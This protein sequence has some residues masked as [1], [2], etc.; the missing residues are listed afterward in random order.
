M[1]SYEKNKSSGLWSVRFREVNSDG[2][3]H[4]KR[5]SGY[6]TKKEA[7]YGY[8]D[9]IKQKETSDKIAEEKKKEKEDPRNIKFDSLL[10]MYFSF[11]EQRV[12]ETTLY[13]L[14]NKI[15]NKILPFFTG[16]K[17]KEITPAKI[18]EWQQT[19][20]EYSYKYQKNLNA[21]LASIFNYAYKYHNIE[22]VMDKVDR[23]RNLEVKKEM[24][25][26][27]PEEFNKFIEKVPK[28]EYEYLYRFL[29]VTGCRRGEALAL[30]WDDIDLEKGIIKINK[31]AVF[32]VGENGV[33]WKITT[34]KNAG[35]NRTITIPTFFC[36][37]LI[38]Y[39][40]WQRNNVENVVFVF[41]GKGPLPPTTI[42]RIMTKAAVEAN[43]P[44][45]RIHDLRH[46]CASYLIH[47]GI[48]IVAVSKR[49]GHTSIEQTLNTYSHM[50]PDDQTMILNA[51]EDLKK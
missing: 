49:L 3:P 7:Q 17:I 28:K 27:S 40:E 39:K 15:N 50:M 30:S 4:Q 6:K 34:P 9:Y 43:V 38:K 11:K 46:S 1:P 36:K 42:E 8:E 14:R 22:N 24:L 19:I 35:S 2:E 31:N 45:I 41:C 47:K 37:M 29:Y 18:L 32:K 5:L 23:P 44:R 13:D 16:M 21:H 25:F 48:S 10:D 20:K 12:K 33:P 26:W 51:L